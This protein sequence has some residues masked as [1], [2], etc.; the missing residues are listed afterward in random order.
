MRLTILRFSLFIIL[1]STTFTGA[2]G[3]QLLLNLHS[4]EVEE[5][6]LTAVRS[7][8]FDSNL[9]LIYQNNGNVIS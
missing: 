8:K 5:H 2:Y 3:Q 4:G 7:L 6:V 9:L 1:I